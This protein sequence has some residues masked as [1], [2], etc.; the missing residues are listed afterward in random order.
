MTLLRDLMLADLERGLAIARDGHEVVP[1]WRILAPDGDFLVLTQFDPDKPEQRERAFA[2][3]PRFMA[4]KFATGFVLTAETWLGPERTRSGEEAV[5][6]IGVSHHERMAVIRRIR[7][8]P[9]LAFG[10]AEWLP[11]DA[12]DD[13][14]FR[15]LPSGQSTVTAEEATMLAA[16]FAED[17]E[18]PARP[19]GASTWKQ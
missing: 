15:V 6:T 1:A 19:A 11:A 14:Y 13:T 8:T 17:G 3:V 18:L 10:P 9:A 4:W 2:L 7:R 16:V 12:L 5:L